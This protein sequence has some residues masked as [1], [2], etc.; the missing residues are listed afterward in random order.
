MDA[1]IVELYKRYNNTLRPL[2]SE[3]EGRNERFEEPLLLNTASMFDSIALSDSG[4]DEETRSYYMEQALRYLDTSISQSYQYL[5]RNLHEKMLAFEK[6]C[7][8]PGRKTLDDGK[9]IGKYLELQRQAQ[10]C[11]REG[12][13]KEDLNAL[14][15]FASAYLT[16]SKIEKLIDRELPVQIMQNTRRNS[17]NWTIVGWGLSI[18]ISVVVGKVVNTF[19][20]HIIEWFKAWMNV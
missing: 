9:F 13:T 3:I 20:D 6:R 8:A 2:V 12:R 4:D 14:P 11:V 15:Y 18:L 10:D 16:Y 17:R 5:I 1:R 19:G 7:E